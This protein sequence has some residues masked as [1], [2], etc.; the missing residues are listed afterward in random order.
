VTSSNTETDVLAAEALAKLGLAP[1]ELLLERYELGSLL[2]AGAMGL[3]FEARQVILD[4]PVAVK[5]LVGAAE[6]ARAEARFLREAR[7][8]AKIKSPFVARVLDAATVKGI[9]CIV[10]ERLQGLDLHDWLKG[11]G[12]LSVPNTATL[13]RQCCDA[14]GE[15]HRAGIV[16]RDLKPSNVFVVADRGVISAKILDFGVA[17][18][19]TGFDPESRNATRSIAG[20]PDYM[21]PEQIDGVEDL[22]GRADVWSLG[23]MMYEL[24]SGRR[25][26]DGATFSALVRQVTAEPHA[27]LAV[28]AP[29]VDA[30]FAAIIDR[31]LAKDRAA[32]FASMDELAAELEPFEDRSQAVA[33]SAVV[34]G[35]QAAPSRGVAV[36]TGS[37]SSSSRE[38][39]SQTMRADDLPEAPSVPSHAFTTRAETPPS[40]VEGPKAASVQVVIPGPARRKTMVVFAGA[41]LLMA[42]GSFAFRARGPGD[43][44]HGPVPVAPA[45]PSK[46]EPLEAT[47]APGPSPAPAARD[48][49]ENPSAGA[50][51]VAAV[52]DAGSSV[53]PVAPAR[54]SS[55]TPAVAPAAKKPGPARA[56]S[57]LEER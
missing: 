13:A 55:P 6:D 48:V 8:L 17:K 51:A 11:H 50:T 47:P 14:L 54:P 43:A 41:A 22:D 45:A 30:R 35:Y 4:Q 7:A 10:L 36:R 49:G 38:A 52:V 42:V 25:P 44:L 18:L 53:A 16:H 21:A 12:V 20:T 27:P 23:V 9:P 34:A 26:F 40:Q 24:V 56:P 15:A 3:V 39:F 46:A 28:V 1:G 32:R 29:G 2:G 37:S 5:M 33:A 31:C 57:L 19:M